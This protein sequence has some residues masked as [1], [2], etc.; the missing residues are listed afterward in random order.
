[1]EEQASGLRLL[2]EEV[3]REMRAALA[4][5][6]RRSGVRLLAVAS[7]KGG[8]GKTNLAVNLALAFR[9]RGLPVLLVD[10]DVGLANADLVLGVEPRVHLGHV[11]SGQARLSE[12]VVPG[13]LGL[14]L[15]PGG[16]ALEDLAALSPQQMLGLLEDLTL[17]V[18]GGEVVLLDLGAGL[19]PLVRALLGAA[20]EVVVVVTPEPTSLADAY[21]TIKVLAREGADACIYLVVNQA[22][23]P[24]EARDVARTLARAARRYL[25]VAVTDLGYV[26]RDASVPRAVR[27]RRPFLLAR[28]NAPASRAVRELAGRLLAGEGTPA[29]RA[30]G[31]GEFLRR[32]LGGLARGRE[33]EQPV[34]QEAAEG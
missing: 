22:E 32:V 33:H 20:P 4:A 5:R 21:A 2:A 10:A 34:A 19:S 26:P 29:Y 12:A 3:R 31:W 13:P 24:A 14:R 9:E 8:T 30:T 15:L 6:A 27:E 17:T 16:T 25:G 11:L 28:P 23:S 7:G 18:P 1:M